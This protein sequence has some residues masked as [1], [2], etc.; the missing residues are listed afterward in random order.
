MIEEKVIRLLIRQLVDIQMQAEKIMSGDNSGAAIENF[1]R[2]SSD[3]KDYIERNVK[4]EEVRNFVENIQDLNYSKVHF[5]LWEFLILPLFWTMWVKDYLVRRQLTQQVRE[6]RG[7]Y[8]SL[9]FL[10][11]R[12]SNN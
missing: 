2:Y 1:A 4:D 3:L 9:E 11:K 7:S 12:E 10:I 5:Q 6:L 8:A